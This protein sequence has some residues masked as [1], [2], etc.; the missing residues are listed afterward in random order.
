MI[1]RAYLPGTSDALATLEVYTLGEREE[2]RREYTLEEVLAMVPSSPQVLAWDARR[3]AVTTRVA[4]I[5]GMVVGM[6]VGQVVGFADVAS[7]GYIDML[8]V[9]PQ[10]NGRGVASALL[11]SLGDGFLWTYAAITARGFY[12]R[13]GFVVEGMREVEVRGRKLS[14]WR[15]SRAAV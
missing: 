7:D 11:A 9:H 12:E 3:S 4:A 1:V 6:V 14:E 13:S 10:Y 2:A 15:M 8:S 5:D